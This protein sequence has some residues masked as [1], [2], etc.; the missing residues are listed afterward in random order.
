MSCRHEALHGLR[1]KVEAE[2]SRII[3]LVQVVG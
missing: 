2:I 3:Q 1:L